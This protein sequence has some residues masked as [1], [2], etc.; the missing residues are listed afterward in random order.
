LANPPRADKK[1]P[2]KLANRRG[3]GENGD[4]ATIL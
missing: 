1:N 4:Q 3:I 2:K